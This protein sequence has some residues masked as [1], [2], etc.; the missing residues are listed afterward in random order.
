MFNKPIAYDK[1]NSKCR[2]PLESVS[3]V[4]RSHRDST[5]GPA[6]G[7]EDE[8]ECLL[9]EPYGHFVPPVLAC[10]LSLVG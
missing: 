4:S 6:L 5:E 2:R 8:D 3:S 10:L 9:R 1:G 7:G